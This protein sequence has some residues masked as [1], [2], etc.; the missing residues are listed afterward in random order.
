MSHHLLTGRH[1]SPDF[2]QAEK[3]ERVLCRDGS[4]HSKTDLCEFHPLVIAA[5]IWAVYGAKI[6]RQNGTFKKHLT[7]MWRVASRHAEKTRFSFRREHVRSMYSN[8]RF[9]PQLDRCIHTSP[10]EPYQRGNCTRVRFKQSL[11]RKNAP[12]PAGATAISS[13]SL[14]SSLSTCAWTPLCFTAAEKRC[15]FKNVF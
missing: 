1:E 6:T 8:L 11:A 12:K 7:G 13:P 10:D 2:S 15:L 3:G 14:S 5:V 9:H 4:S